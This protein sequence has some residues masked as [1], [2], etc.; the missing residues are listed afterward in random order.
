MFLT[1]PAPRRVACG[2]L[3]WPVGMRHRGILYIPLDLITDKGR[4]ELLEAFLRPVPL[5]VL[6]PLIVHEMPTC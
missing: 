3:C 6:P 1:V 4:A 2:W 5:T